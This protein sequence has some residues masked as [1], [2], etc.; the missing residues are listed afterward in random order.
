LTHL[1][2]YNVRWTNLDPALSSDS[3]ELPQL[4]ELHLS[5]CNPGDI[6]PTLSTPSLQTL[7]AHSDRS[8]TNLR[9]NLP[10]YTNLREL[11]W[12]DLGTETCFQEILELSP[13]LIR[14]SNYVFGKEEELDLW[15]IEEPATIL[16]IVARD[17]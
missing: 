15:E 13:N 2:L 11:Q 12:G 7:I 8:R 3:V 10:Q 14:Y 4:L 16:D 1:S 17:L 9:A 6:L 5:G